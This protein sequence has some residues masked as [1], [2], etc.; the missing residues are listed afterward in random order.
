MRLILQYASKDTI[1]LWQLA[2][3][4]PIF[5]CSSFFFFPGETDHAPVTWDYVLRVPHN[6][7][8]RTQQQQQPARLLPSQLCHS[9]TLSVSWSTLISNVLSLS[10]CPSL[11]VLKR[12][13]DLSCSITCLCHLKWDT[14]RW[15]SLSQT[16][17]LACSLCTCESF[18]NSHFLSPS[19]F[20]W[21][22]LSHSSIRLSLFS[23]SPLACHSVKLYLVTAISSNQR[24]YNTRRVGDENTQACNKFFLS[25]C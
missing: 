23:L 13:T 10:L 11:F 9:V 8:R 3:A 18:A 22:L 4:W 1:N 6:L 19:P 25:P 24:T 16:I 14:Q 2:T 5:F 15:T 7:I 20:H 17:S 12:T 21:R